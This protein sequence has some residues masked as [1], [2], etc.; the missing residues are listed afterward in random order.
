MVDP[1]LLPTLPLHM[2]L[3]GI[4]TYS[5]NFQACCPAANSTTFAD[6]AQTLP[7]TQ[8]PSTCSFYESSYLVLDIAGPHA[9]CTMLSLWPIDKR[10]AHHVDTP[11]HT[12]AHHVDTPYGALLTPNTHATVLVI[13]RVLRVYMRF[14]YIY[15]CVMMLMLMPMTVLMMMELYP[16][17]H[18]RVTGPADVGLFCD[19]CDVCQLVGRVRVW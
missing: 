18:L 14:T 16:N 17:R 8:D 13:Q 9:S 10:C 12:P 6:L 19:V 2:D 7:C 11:A 3:P 15:V 4:A 5:H 1:F